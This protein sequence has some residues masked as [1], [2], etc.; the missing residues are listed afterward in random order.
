MS[1]ASLKHRCRRKFPKGVARH[2]H[3]KGCRAAVVVCIVCQHRG[4]RHFLRHKGELDLVAG[5]LVNGGKGVGFAALNAGT[6]HLLALGLCSQ[7][8]RDS[9]AAGVDMDASIAALLHTLRH[10]RARAPEISD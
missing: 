7:C 6:D 10:V 9:G 1:P 3:S 5:E 8:S 2:Q 4:C